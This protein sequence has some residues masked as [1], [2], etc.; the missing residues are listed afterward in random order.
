MS[1]V[2]DLSRIRYFS[3]PQLCRF[4]PHPFSYFCLTNLPYGRV[5]VAVFRF[6]QKEYQLR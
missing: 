4:T 2:A 6:S 5:R 3:L 1:R